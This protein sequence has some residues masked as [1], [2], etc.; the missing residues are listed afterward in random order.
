ML[1]SGLKAISGSHCPLKIPLKLTLLA[2]YPA[3]YPPHPRFY[4]LILTDPSQFLL[5][6]DLCTC[7]SSNTLFLTSPPVLLSP[8]SVLLRFKGGLFPSE[9]MTTVL[10]CPALFTAIAPVP[11]K[12]RVD[13]K[14]QFND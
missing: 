13:N 8:T 1:L 3:T 12:H 6:L 7:C 10:F 14:Y 4:S 9:H 11:S 2:S 5:P